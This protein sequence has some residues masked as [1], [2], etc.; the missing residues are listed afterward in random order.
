MDI[1]GLIKAAGRV[2]LLKIYILPVVSQRL[3]VKYA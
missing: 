2:S 1:E 3:I